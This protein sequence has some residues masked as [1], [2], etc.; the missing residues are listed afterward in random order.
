MTQATTISRCPVSASARDLDLFSDDFILHPYPFLNA[1]RKE[2]PVFYNA[3]IGYWIVT[4]YDDVRDCLLNREA[5][6]AANVLEPVTA[7]YPSTGAILRDAGVKFGPALAD[8]DDPGHGIHRPP[9]FKNFNPKRLREMESFV[10]TEATKALDQIVDRG[11]AD[12]IDD[13]VFWIPATVIFHMMRI[14]EADIPKVRGFVTAM[15]GLA[16]GQPDEAE[17]NRL[18]HEVVDYWNYA[19]QHVL[20]L[21]DNLGDDFI[22]DAVRLHIEDEE[23]WSLDYLTSLTSNFLFAGHETTSAQLGSAIRALLENREQWKAICADPSLIPNAIEESLRYVGSVLAWRRMTKQAVRVGNVEIPEGEKVLVSFGAANRDDCIFSDPDT[24]DIT[25]KNANR[26]VTFGYGAH[27][28]MGAPLSRMEM[29]V[30]L[31]E[32][33]RRLPSIELVEGQQWSYP[34]TVSHRGLHHL[35]VRWP[36]P[37][38]GKLP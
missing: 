3:E 2:E 25:R 11:E 21:K 10:H 18:A 30:L 19:K 38:G 29:R 22:S 33:A 27:T 1:V 20:N 17:Q 8:E 23:N 12:L 34:R 35:L 26:H 32:L 4:R 14:P 16:W 5:F 9:I 36:V 6:S 31:E 15:A 24:F 28:C 7:I 13:Y 37:V